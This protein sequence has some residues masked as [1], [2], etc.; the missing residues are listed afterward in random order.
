MT[1]AALVSLED[2]KQFIEVRDDSAA[3]DRKLLTLARTATRQLERFTRSEFVKQERTEYYDARTLIK[4]NGQIVPTL[5]RLKARPVDFAETFTIHHDPD[6]VFPA[7]SALA[8]DG[9]FYDASKHRLTITA[10]LTASPQSIKVV[11]TGGYEVVDPGE[12]DTEDDSG[13]T[14]ANMSAA[15]PE[16][17]KMACIA[18]VLFLWEKLARQNIGTVAADGG[19]E[20]ETGFILAPEAMDLA[21]G[22]SNIIL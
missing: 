4:N 3:F 21:A 16:A 15:A 9:W 20:F 17:L 11:Y 2:I 22:F 18:Q 5:L 12:G 1:T 6:R 10:P 8:S 14:D 7:A 19:Q 13:D